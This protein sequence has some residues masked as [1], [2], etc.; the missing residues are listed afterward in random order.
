[1]VLLL[2]RVLA[3]W[4]LHR[5]GRNNMANFN[6]DDYETVKSRKKRFYKDHPDGRIIVKMVNSDHLEYALFK[7]AVYLTP[8]DQEKNLPKATGFALE[9]RDK[10]VKTSKYGKEYESVNYTSWTENC[11]ESAVGRALDNAGYASSPSRDEMAKVGRMT[12]TIR[13]TNKTVSSTS[14]KP[15]ATKNI[16]NWCE[17]H[18][19]SMKLNKNGNPY[20]RDDVR[21]FCNGYGFPDEKNK[22]KR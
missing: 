15:Q 1:M 3:E 2:G 4:E 7:A 18:K 13:K 14:N 9:I 17:V 22:D 8:E 20:H 12:N 5:F 11:E 19:C 21:G 10:E 16:E 6:L